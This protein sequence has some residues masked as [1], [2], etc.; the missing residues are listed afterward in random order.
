MKETL[1]MVERLH[2]NGVMGPMRSVGRGRGILPG[3]GR[4]AGSRYLRAVRAS[5]VNPHPDADL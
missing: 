4:D 2:A 3:A 1:A 5:A